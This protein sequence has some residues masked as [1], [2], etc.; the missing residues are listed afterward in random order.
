MEADP[1]NPFTGVKV[2]TPALSTVNVPFPTTVIV[3]S[4]SNVVGSRSTDPVWKIPEG[5]TAA[6]SLVMI[7]IVLQ[8]SYG[9]SFSSVELLYQILLEFI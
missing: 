7:F 5:F 9:C 1:R 4:T 2:T 8:Y 3:V 6:L